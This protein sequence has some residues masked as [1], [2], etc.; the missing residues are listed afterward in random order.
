MPSAKFDFLHC[1]LSPSLRKSIAYCERV[2]NFT[3]DDIESVLSTS[4][5]T[6]RDFDKEVA[7]S[8]LRYMQDSGNIFDPDYAF[9]TILYNAFKDIGVFNMVNTVLQMPSDTTE[10]KIS[11][12]RNGDTLTVYSESKELM[13][14]NY[15]F[16]QQIMF[17]SSKNFIKFAMWKE[18]RTENIDFLYRFLS[19]VVSASRDIEGFAKYPD[20]NKEIGTIYLQQLKALENAI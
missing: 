6:M 3:A 13:Y 2:N 16:M 20:I 8:L 19:F 7:K 5:E 18:K 17:G 11:I 15:T 9:S 10:T 4:I 1:H 12:F 14:E